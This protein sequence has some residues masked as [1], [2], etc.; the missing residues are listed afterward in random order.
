MKYLKTDL[1]GKIRN[2]PHFKSEALLPVFEAVV[3]SI[4]AIEERGNLSGGEVEVRVVRESQPMLFDMDESGITGFIITDNGI[5]FNEA[6]YDS[7]LTSDSIHKQSLGCKGVGRFLSLKAFES[8]EIESVYAADKRCMNRK[9]T[10]TIN[11]GV[12]ENHHAETTEAVRTVVQLRGFKN[13]YQRLASAYKTT[14][15]IAQRI[16]EHC[17]SYFISGEAPRVTVLD[18]DERLVLNEIFD[19]DIKNNIMLEKLQLEGHEFSLVHIKLYSTHEKMH[20]AVLCANR[21]DVKSLSLAKSLGTSSQFDDADRRFTYALYVTSAY[22]DKTVDNYRLD[23]EIPEDTPLLKEY[24]VVSMKQVEGAV[25]GAAKDFLRE[26]LEKARVRKLAIVE[27]Y[28]ANENPALRSVPFYCPEIFEEI[29]PNS[30]PEKINEVLYRHK[31]RAE[32]AI[33]KNSEKLLKTQAKS[34]AEVEAD[35]QALT[36][37]ITVF[38]KDNLVNYLCDRNRM[39]ALLEKKLELNVDGKFPNEDIIHDLIFPRKATTD[40]IGF[41]NH[42]LWII[43]E[44]L[45]FHAF[46]ASDKPLNQTTYS[47]SDERPD[48]VAFAEVDADKIARAVSILEFKKPQRTNFDEDPTRQLYRYLREIKESK[49]VRLPNG[50]DLNVGETTRYYCYAICDITSAIH[51]YA[52][53]NGN[54]A[55]LK[56]ELGYYMYNRA[57]N[58]HT[59]ILH[60]DKIVVDAKR[61][62][63]AFFEKLG[64]G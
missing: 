21:R 6:N 58:A 1:K 19:R 30:T 51:E 14:A 59:E 34:I 10:F 45:T 63:K 48:I 40:Q 52:E 15:K 50:R 27:R 7:F 8:V 61:R 4:Q 41:E 32:F 39:I 11:D 29:E 53:N 47:G 26:F 55:R 49:K 16:M 3:N 24:G 25:A 56:G 42:N 17:L 64:I 2:L 12:K 60:F 5:G 20:N 46:A 54:Y 18:R 28:I 37:Q 13:E 38:Q 35:Y 23:F 62:H 33:R 22:L 31:G 9:F 44:C 36:A 57:L 43:D